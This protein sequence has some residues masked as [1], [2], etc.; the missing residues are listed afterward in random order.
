MKEVFYEILMYLI[1]YVLLIVI[2]SVLISLI[3]SIFQVQD[4]SLALLY[5]IIVTVFYINKNYVAVIQGL[6]SLW[7]M[8]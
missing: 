5:K 3:L 7:R 6:M 4:Q 8:T 1:Y 2:G